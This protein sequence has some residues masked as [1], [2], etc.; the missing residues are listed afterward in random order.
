MRHFA[1]I[2]TWLAFASLLGCA[3]SLDKARDS[4]EQGYYTDAVFYYEQAIE[5]DKSAARAKVELADLIAAKARRREKARPKEAESLYFDAMKVLPAHDPSLSGLV[6][7]YRRNDRHADATKLLEEA[8]AT[9]KC[10]ACKRLGVVVLVERG[11]AEMEA[12]NWE[13]ARGH[14]EAALKLNAQPGAALAI[15]RAELAAKRVPEAIAA[16][17]AAVPLM[18]QADAATQGSFMKVRERLLASTLARDEVK[19]ADRLAGIVLANEGGKGPVG[20]RMQVA[21]HLRDKG[22]NEQARTRYEALLAE[23][24]GRPAPTQTQREE[25]HKRLIKQYRVRATDF[26]AQGKPNEADKAILRAIELGADD[27]EIKL[28]RVLSVAVKTG[29]RPAL[30]SLDKVPGNTP[31]VV[32]TRAILHS[33][34][35]QELLAEGDIEGARQELAAARKTHPGMPEVHLAGAQVLAV[36]DVEDL[37]RRQLSQLRKTGLGYDSEIKRFAEALGEIE[38]AR[39]AA[40]ERKRDYPYRAPWFAKTAKKLEDEIHRKYHHAVAF[41]EEPNTLVQFN[42]NRLEEITIRLRGPEDFE[43]EIV[44]IA[45]GKREVTIPDTGFVIMRIGRQKRSFVAEPY[46]RVTIDL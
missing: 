46:T 20:M 38:W 23:G 36:S 34:R 31:G 19:T 26:L 32:Q 14:Y 13:A 5:D 40:A 22:D 4:A 10:A 15:V 37:G 28:Q 35:V 12:E 8:A 3:T 7:M 44:L 6:R 21:A 2:A 11:D 39:A 29:A 27:W 30:A 24:E 25:I 33:L 18:G 9:G 16:L 17:E 45:G 43:D 41:R 42:N 1:P